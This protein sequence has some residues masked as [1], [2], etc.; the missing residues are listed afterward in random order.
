M[1]Y[2]FNYFYIAILTTYFKIGVKPEI[3]IE[4]VNFRNIDINYSINPDFNQ[5]DNNLISDS[6]DDEESFKIIG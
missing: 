2:I 6:S 5:E 4:K 1:L 3:I